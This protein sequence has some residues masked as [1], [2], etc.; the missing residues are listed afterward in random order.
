MNAPTVH[1]HALELGGNAGIKDSL[2]HIL[3]NA[4]TVI[5]KDKR[6]DA[7]F[8][9]RGEI[10][11]V[12]AGIAS[13]TEHFDDD[14]LD[15][16]NVVL[17]LAPLGLRNAEADIPLAKVLL[18]AKVALPDIDAINEMSSFASHMLFS[19]ID[20]AALANHDDAHLTGILHLFLDLMGD[21][22]SQDRGL[23]IG[24][25]VGWTMTWT[26]RPACMA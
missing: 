24:D 9:G 26:S 21:I 20:S 2:L 13:I 10:D 14:V 5:Q 11:L 17:S 12:G 7:I 18:D 4:R 3:R 15:M 25:L 8:L 23:G 19:D 6:A 22:V 16:L 1:L